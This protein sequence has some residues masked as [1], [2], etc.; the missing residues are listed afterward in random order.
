VVCNT[1]NSKAVTVYVNGSVASVRFMFLCAEFRSWI[2][3]KSVT[4]MMDV[5]PLN[6]TFFIEFLFFSLLC[7]SFS[8]FFSLYFCRIKIMVFCR[9][10]F[11]SR[12]ALVSV[13]DMLFF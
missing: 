9:I 4:R 2:E 3:N 5:I 8:S 11:D 10:F 13:C 7:L 12:V 1:K 6:L